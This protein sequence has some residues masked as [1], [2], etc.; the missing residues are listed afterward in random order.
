M[1]LA[2]TLV[3]ALAYAAL[4]MAGHQPTMVA[5]LS[6]VPQEKESKTQPKQVTLAKDSQSDKWGEVAFNHENHATKNY[7]ADETK[8][9]GCT[10][11]HHTDQPTAA[12]KPPLK[13]SERNVALTD[14]LLK[15]ADAAPVKTCRAC[16]LQTGDDSKPIPTVTYADKPNPVKMTNDNAYHINCN[17]CHDAVM[18]AKP[19]LKGKLGGSGPQDC[20]LCHKQVS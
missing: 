19:A 2:I 13:T 4:L 15:T 6:P 5:A 18:K 17:T 3:A 11:C 16:H 10:E 20:A 7:S 1:K 9:I 12:L 14:A 8:P